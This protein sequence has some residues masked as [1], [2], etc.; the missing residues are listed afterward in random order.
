[1]N[2]NMNTFISS[3]YIQNFSVSLNFSEIKDYKP[4]ERIIFISIKSRT[5]NFLEIFKTSVACNCVGEVTKV[6]ME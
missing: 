3:L 6:N 2:M 4:F 5:N 1:M